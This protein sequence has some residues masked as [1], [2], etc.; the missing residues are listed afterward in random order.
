[1]HEFSVSSQCRQTGELV[2]ESLKL[3]G[4]D[5]YRT[6][7]QADGIAAATSNP[8]DVILLECSLPGADSTDLLL[9]LKAA[10]KEWDTNIVMLTESQRDDKLVL[11]L[12][13]GA[14]DFVSKPVSVPVLRARV[15]HAVRVRNSRRRLREDK[16]MAEHAT[17]QNAAFLT[18]IGQEIRTPMTAILGFA[19]VLDVYGDRAKAPLHRLESIDTIKRHS[20]CLLSMVNDLLDLA[21]ASG[22]TLD[23]ARRR[24]SVLDVVRDAISLVSSDAARKHLPLKA[25]FDGPIPESVHTDP[26][27]LRQIILNFLSNAIKYTDRGNVSISVSTLQSDVDGPRM[28]FQVTDTGIGIASKEQKDIFQPFSHLSP[29]RKYGHTGLGLSVSKQIAELL[30]GTISVSSELGHGSSFTLTIAAGALEG[31]RMFGN[32]TKEDLTGASSLFPLSSPS[33]ALNC[34]VLLA[35][36]SP[37]TQRLLDFMLSKQGADVVVADNG[38]VAAKLAMAARDEQRPFDVI[39][40]DIDM[41][42]MDGNVAVATL[43][44]AGYDLPV[45]ALTARS[46]ETDRRGCLDAGFDAFVSKPVFHKQLIEL[47][48]AFS[49]PKSAANESTMSET[50]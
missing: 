38:E 31:V 29:G 11:A 32:V 41:P 3:D 45:I 47:V 12:E 16:E 49:E 14:T 22:G 23:I 7:T 35:E 27:R 9:K 44:E 26:D 20:E 17:A 13:F 18:K 19:D 24:C 28:R 50:T 8:P 34:R 30:G 43:R 42:I 5:V 10:T 33:D 4:Y 48:R 39:L 36:D 25:V 21:N 37:D 2:A 40:M 15:R 1:M 6:T 46:S